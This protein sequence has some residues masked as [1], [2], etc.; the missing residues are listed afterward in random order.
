MWMDIGQMGGGD[1]LFQKI[2]NG[3][4]ASKI[5]ICCVTEKYAQSPN[6]NR[7]VSF[8]VSGIMNKISCNYFIVVHVF[9]VNLAVNLG[10]PI[11]PLLMEKMNWPPAGSMGPIFGEYL[12]IRLASC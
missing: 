7:E 12:F 3:I 8:R 2:D 1:K 4:R 10:K 5:M 6:C 9:Q 11:L